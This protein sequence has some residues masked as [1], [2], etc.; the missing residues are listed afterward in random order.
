MKNSKVYFLI[1]FVVNL[2]H[3][4]G[5]DTILYLK[6]KKILVDNIGNI[7]G[8][9]DFV[10]TKYF[11][12]QQQKTFSIKTYGTL[13]NI[14]VTNTLRVLLF[15][16]DFQK[17]LFLDSQLS[18]NGEVIELSQLGFEQT[19]LVCS[20]INNGF[21]IYHQANNELIRFNQ[22]LEI[23]IRTGNLKRLL[24][25]DIQPNFMIEHNGRL[26]LNDPETGILVFDIY[27]AYLKTIPLLHLTN[28]QLN[29]PYLFYTRE[30]QFNVFNLITFET[31][32]LLKLSDDCNN[33]YISNE[34]CYLHCKD[35]IQIN[36]CLK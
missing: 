3:A 29:Y 4:S 36:T 23:T 26:Y 24:N 25:I 17:I 1:L 13:E 5:Q 34:K 7:Y 31:I 27:G 14:D 8:I 20:S 12:N 6:A 15:F 10:I 19:L 33:V 21:W 30:K 9:N 35:Y 16:K 32:Q 22:S 2:F 18:P 11:A 28:F